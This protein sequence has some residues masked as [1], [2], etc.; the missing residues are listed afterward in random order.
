[1]SSP[2][3]PPYTSEISM[4]DRPDDSSPGGPQSDRP[5]ANMPNH[6]LSPPNPR[7]DISGP[8]Q[9]SSQNDMDFHPSSSQPSTSSSQEDPTLTA[10]AK[11]TKIDAARLKFAGNASEASLF[12][13][14]LP[15]TIQGWCKICTLKPN[16][17]NGYIQVSWEGANHFAVLQEMV[18][19][20]QGKIAGVGEQYSHLCGQPACTHGPRKCIK[21]HPGYH[22]ALEFEASGLHKEVDNN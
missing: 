14:D 12:L 18:L 16:K 20:A 11:Q 10:Y 6:P 22:S 19:W 7:F 13:L 21:A 15:H 9:S 5:D 2:S 8:L 3:S 17:H 4:S 1:M